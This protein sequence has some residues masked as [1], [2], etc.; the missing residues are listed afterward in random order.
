MEIK[1]E[2]EKELQAIKENESSL[3][4]ASLKDESETVLNG[5]SFDDSDLN[6]LLEKSLLNKII[7]PD[8]NT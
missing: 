2:I 8:C 3:V 5:K 1:S 7:P 4:F 6:S